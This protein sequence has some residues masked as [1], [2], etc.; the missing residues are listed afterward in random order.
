MR[1]TMMLLAGHSQVSDYKINTTKKESYELF[2]V[3]GALETVRCTETADRAVTV[4]VDHGE[5]RGDAKFFV[6]P[7]TTFSQKAD[8]IHQAVSRAKLICNQKYDLPGVDG[9]N[10]QNMIKSNF[11]EYDPTELAA[12]IAKAVF[13]AD[14]ESDATINAVEVFIN[15]YQEQVINSRGINKIQTRYDAMVEIIPTANGNGQSVELYE[16]YNF[17]IL[18]EE[19]LKNDVRAKLA[20]V[21]ARLVAAPP[22]EMPH[23]KVILKDLELSQ[24]FH[25]L[26]DDLNYATIYSQSNVFSKGDVVQTTP[27]GDLLTMGMVD[28]MP[29]DVNSSMFDSDGVALHAQTLIQDGKV[30]GYYGSSR[31]GQYIGEEPTGNLRCLCAAPGTATD[32]ETGPYLEVASMSAFQL[33]LYSDY[34]GG[35]IRL[36]YYHDGEKI[37]PV[38]GISF[39]G[40]LRASL[41]NIRLSAETT[42]REGYTGPAKAILEGMNIY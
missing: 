23:C 34:L 15:C 3:K 27:T 24:L 5:Y 12:K 8:L 18:D 30:V 10:G 19:A 39:S 41:N 7:S 26:A 16:Q 28:A 21:K 1:E 22:A 9:C 40:S 17:N 14:A 32:F 2:F 25:M 37:I 35:E 13:D 4:Y 6:Y 31:F 33:D 42:T 36:A 20:E 11:A 29:G 38:T